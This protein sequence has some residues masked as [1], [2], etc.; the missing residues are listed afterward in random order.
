[1][2]AIWSRLYK[3]RPKYKIPRLVFQQ[4]VKFITNSVIN[5]VANFFFK[6]KNQNFTKI[7]IWHGASSEIKC[8]PFLTHLKIYLASHFFKLNPWFLHQKKIT[9]LLTSSNS[10]PFIFETPGKLQYG[11]GRSSTWL[12][13]LLMSTIWW[14][15]P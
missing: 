14:V 1:M 12:S 7:N 8:R 3:Y 13:A 2:Y 10:I 5:L 15:I 11:N 4:I 6:C 9:K